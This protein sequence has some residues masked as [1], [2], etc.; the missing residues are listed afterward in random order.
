VAAPLAVRFHAWELEEPRAGALTRARVELENAGAVAWG[1]DVKASYHWLDELGNPIVWDGLRTSLPQQVE[2]GERVDVEIAVRC[3]IPPGRY[4]FAVDLVAERRAWFGEVGGEAPQ[5]EVD[6]LPRVNVSRLDDVADVHLP[7]GCEPGPHWAERVLAAHREGYAVVA[8]SIEA[9]RRL[10]PALE[11]WAPG[12]GRV[13]G[14]SAPL[15][16]PSVLRGVRLERLPD[17]EGLPAF[18]PP[19]DEPWVYDGRIV[20]TL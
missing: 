6:V 20:L 3:P 19:A 5:R 7:D 2:L 11:P 1:D 12:P 4:R 14:F 8:G 15:L 9:P 16:C 10:R 18:A 13:P 17:I